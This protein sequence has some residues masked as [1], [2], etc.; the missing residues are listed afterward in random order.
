MGWEL[1]ASNHAGG[2]AFTI[3]FQATRS[4]PAPEG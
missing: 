3:D 4:T 2:A 1:T